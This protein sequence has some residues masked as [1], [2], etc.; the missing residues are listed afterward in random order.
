MEGAT[1]RHLLLV[2]PHG[3]VKGV[4]LDF[5]CMRRGEWQLASIH[6]PVVCVFCMDPGADPRSG[7]SEC[8]SP[9][10]FPYGEPDAHHF[11]KQ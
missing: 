8:W 4:A 1:V 2:D 6:K 5:K 11:W 10:A 3:Q 9:G 7:V